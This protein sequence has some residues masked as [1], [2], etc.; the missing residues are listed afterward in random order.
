LHNAAIKPNEAMLYN[1]PRTVAYES[2][3]EE[4]F[5]FLSNRLRVQLPLGLDI[6]MMMNT[7]TGWLAA[8]PLDVNQEKTK[9]DSRRVGMSSI[10]TIPARYKN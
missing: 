5:F 6:I 9:A 4:S 1:M 7:M 3:L 10:L 2:N 8:S